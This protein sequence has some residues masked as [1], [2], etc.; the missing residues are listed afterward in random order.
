MASN[1]FV[2]PVWHQV[3]FDWARP[4][5]P[6]KYLSVT[7]PIYGI[8][9]VLMQVIH[10]VLLEIL[11]NGILC[12]GFVYLC[13]LCKLVTRAELGGM[14]RQV[15]KQKSNMSMKGVQSEL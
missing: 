8:Y 9:I 13:L 1:L 12:C 15:L 10:S 11:L 5:V 3:L 2:L 7:L 4:V 6:Y 14:I